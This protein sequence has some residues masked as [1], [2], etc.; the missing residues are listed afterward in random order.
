MPEEIIPS[1][2]KDFERQKIK[3]T[4][5][6]HTGPLG[7]RGAAGK[8]GRIAHKGGASTS[9]KATGGKGAA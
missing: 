7:K 2:T 3:R 1:H 9:N 4:K 8:A 6:K 5:K